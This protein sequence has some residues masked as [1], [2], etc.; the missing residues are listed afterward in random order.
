MPQPAIAKVSSPALSVTKSLRQKDV[1]SDDARRYRTISIV[2]VYFPLSSVRTDG[3]L[4]VWC[5]IPGILSQ[6]SAARQAAFASYGAPSLSRLRDPAC[7]RDEALRVVGSLALPGTVTTDSA[8]PL[9][10]SGRNTFSYGQ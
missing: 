8:A 6:I 7:S 1:S 5:F 4:P 2:E 9:P 10:C 3:V